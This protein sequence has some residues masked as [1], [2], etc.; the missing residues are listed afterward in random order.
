MTAPP[1]NQL[2]SE[3]LLHFKLPI[4]LFTYIASFSAR[5]SISHFEIFP[6]VLDNGGNS[7]DFDLPSFW[8][9]EIFQWGLNDVGSSDDSDLPSV[10][11]HE[12][13]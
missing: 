1:R 12:L 3:P 10:W 13:E 4:I 6:W 8:C 5:V 7:D 9:C 2:T 11:C